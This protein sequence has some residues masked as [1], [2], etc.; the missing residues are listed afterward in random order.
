M[1]IR[2]IP[3]GAHNVSFPFISDCRLWWIVEF[4]S[5]NISPGPDKS[6]LQVQWILYGSHAHWIS[7]AIPL[8]LRIPPEIGTIY[9]Y[10]KMCSTYRECEENA[11]HESV[12]HLNYSLFKKR[13]AGFSRRMNR[14]CS[15]VLRT[16]K[17]S[18]V[19]PLIFFII[20]DVFA[21]V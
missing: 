18:I 8:Q 21:T 16:L 5:C 9:I 6:A 1:A 3:G 11:W 10:N 20:P 7:R 13:V 12:S 15:I 17:C 2:P 19:G 4:V 14:G